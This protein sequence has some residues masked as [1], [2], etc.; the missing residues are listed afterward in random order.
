MEHVHYASVARIER[1]VWIY[2]DLLSYLSNCLCRYKHASYDPF[3]LSGASFLI[4]KSVAHS[5]L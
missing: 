1:K 5:T 3:L 4:P 2:Y